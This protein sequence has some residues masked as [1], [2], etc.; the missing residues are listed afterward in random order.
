L[1]C[2]ID[3]GGNNTF[4]ELTLMQGGVLVVPKNGYLDTNFTWY[5]NRSFYFNY[6]TSIS[7]CY[8]SQCV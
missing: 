2:I 7:R 1:A 6:C 8:N 3:E 4:Q 5:V